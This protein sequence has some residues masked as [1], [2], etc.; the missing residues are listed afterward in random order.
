MASAER[1][2]DRLDHG[3]VVR[4]RSIA[5][6]PTAVPPCIG[7][8]SGART[9]FRPPRLRIEIGMR[10]V[11]VR[12]SPVGVGSAS[13]GLS[14]CKKRLGTHNGSILVAPELWHH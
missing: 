2:G 8:P 3:V 10:R 12:P 4:V 6:D 1:P 11:T 7:L 9:S 14:G 13:N 5:V